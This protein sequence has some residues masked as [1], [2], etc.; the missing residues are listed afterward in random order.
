MASSSERDP[1]SPT[2]NNIIEKMISSD[3]KAENKNSKKNISSSNPLSSASISSYKIVGIVASEKESIGVVKAING[4]DYFVKKGD[5]LGSEG[6]I[7]EDISSDGLLINRNGK[8]INLQVK[9]KI[10]IKAEN[11]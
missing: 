3:D 7:V 9:N 5:N 6:G 8:K 1:F 11:Q 10:E 2:G 4:L